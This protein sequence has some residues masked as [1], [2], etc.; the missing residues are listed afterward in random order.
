LPS[1]VR[2]RDDGADGIEC[3]VRRTLDDRLVVV[4]DHALPD[5]RAIADTPRADLPAH[6]PDLVHV[7]DACEGLL[8]NLEI[9]NFPR[10][11]GWDPA[12]RVTEL[13]LDLLDGRSDRVLISC[14][15]FA[16]IDLAT[17]R[18]LDTAMLFLSRRPVP[19]LLD[20][21]VAH[22]H[23]AVHPYDTMVDEAFMDEARERDLRV[24]VWLEPVRTKGLSRLV[25]LDVDGLITSEVAA[26]RS[27]V[28][29]T[30]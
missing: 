16:C 1:F 20:R 11:P 22:G 17:S 9:K 7:L 30:R 4:H 5:G 21:V 2:C 19:E 8:V 3:D 24:N 18:G 25:A 15:D 12:Q 29:A 28:D 10:D 13:V 6:I 14:F 27:V 23:S 26:A